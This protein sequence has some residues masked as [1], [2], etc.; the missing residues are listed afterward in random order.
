MT[1]VT[2]TTSGENSL[3][4]AALENSGNP[5]GSGTAVAN[6]PMTSVASGF[7][8]SQWGSHASGYLQVS[9][10]G[11][12]TPTFS[13]NIGANFSINVVAAE[14][15]A[16]VDVTLENFKRGDCNAD[17]EFNIADAVCGLEYLFGGGGS[18]CLDAIDANDDGAVDI[19]DPVYVLS[20][21]F[22]G[23][24]EPT[25]PFGNCGIDPTGD[26]LDCDAYL[27]P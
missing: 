18:T 4:I 16:Q 13:T 1:S 14:F 6:V 26:A 20:A 12:V 10:P 8:G 27:C 19:S 17:G 3:L 7:W 2:L 22:S 15:L 5:N 11:M 23:G 24:P 9:T 21:L 25:D